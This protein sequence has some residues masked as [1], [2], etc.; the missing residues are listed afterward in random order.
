M[1]RI[2]RDL[3]G[4]ASTHTYLSIIG[5]LVMPPGHSSSGIRRPPSHW[6][7]SICP[8][9]SYTYPSIR[10]CGTIRTVPLMAVVGRFVQLARGVQKSQ[11]HEC[12]FIG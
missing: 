7:I 9:V 8:S 11:C 2:T 10:D 3:V 12:Q 4:V 6:A 1:T 5:K